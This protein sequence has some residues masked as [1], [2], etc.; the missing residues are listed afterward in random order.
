[1]TTGQGDEDVFQP[2]VARG[3]AGEIPPGLLEPAEQGR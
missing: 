3:Q 1:V 2:G